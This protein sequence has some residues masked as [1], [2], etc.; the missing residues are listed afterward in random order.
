[1]SDMCVSLSA[2][3]G[4]MLTVHLKYVIACNVF[5]VIS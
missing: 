1:M 5:I 4:L 2:W 3:V